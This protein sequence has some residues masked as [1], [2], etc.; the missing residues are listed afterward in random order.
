MSAIELRFTFSSVDGAKSFI[1]GLGKKSKEA[2]E[3]SPVATSAAPSIDLSLPAGDPVA[4]APAAAAAA[5]VTEPTGGPAPAALIGAGAPVAP[6]PAP[7]A[8]V[9]PAPAAPVAPAP[10]AAVAPAL[11]LP[12]AP[13]AVIPAA[14]EVAGE[15][16]QPQLLTAFTQ[17]GQT[18]GRDAI[19][20]ILTARGVT[21]V[22][23]I[24]VETYPAVLQEIAAALG[25]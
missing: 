12:P 7:V 3:G 16:T 13:V 5:I 22:V 4:P 24:P 9:A 15:I 17:L 11:P 20:T 25:A 8:P 1:A 21:T 23:A 19:S 10:V 2:I 14:P 6:V 18:K